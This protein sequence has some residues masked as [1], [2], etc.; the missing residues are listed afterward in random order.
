MNDDMEF[1]VID[2][3]PCPQGVAAHVAAVLRRAHQTAS[4]IYRGTN[5][6]AVKILHAYGKHTQ[7]EI[8]DDPEYHDISN[9]PGYSQHELFDS[10]GN[11]IPY[12]HIGVDSGGNDQHS[13]DAITEAGRHFGWKI[14]HPY[15]AGI[16]GHHWCFAEKPVA[17]DERVRKYL[18]NLKAD[19]P[20]H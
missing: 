9:P 20:R 13:K 11:T 10:N 6:R 18:D 19:L 1:L 14:I 17:R 7:K 4:S 3:C 12:W 5:P 8:H 2:G 16:E 15:A